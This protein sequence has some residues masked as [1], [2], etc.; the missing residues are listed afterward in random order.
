MK[1]P[2]FL[3]LPLGKEKPRCHQPMESAL[4]AVDHSRKMSP[5]A[6]TQRMARALFMF[7]LWISAFK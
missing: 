7:G 2:S 4:P 6:P 1:I 5:A 3:S